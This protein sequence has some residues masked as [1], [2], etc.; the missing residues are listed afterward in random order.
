ME[1]AETAVSVT[2]SRM[3]VVMRSESY[4]KLLFRCCDRNWLGLH[5]L[6]KKLLLRLK[7]EE[8]TMHKVTTFLVVAI[9]IIKTT[10]PNITTK[11]QT[12]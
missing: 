7:V 4:Y 1:E 12:Y 6:V 10:E 11:D 3:H 9:R 5:R 8:D 2:L